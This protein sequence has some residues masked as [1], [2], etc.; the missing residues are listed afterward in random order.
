MMMMMMFC[1]GVA[2]A[3]VCVFTVVWRRAEGRDDGR[4]GGASGV[5][6]TTALLAAALCYIVSPAVSGVVVLCCVLMKICV[7]KRRG[8][9][10]TRGAV[11]ITGCD[12]G[13]GHTLALQLSHMGVTV[14]AGVLDMKGGGAQRLRARASEKLQVLQ[15]DVTD[16]VQVETARQYVCAQVGRTGLWGLVNNAGILPCP[17]DAEL[18]PLSDY[19]RCMDVNFLSAVHMCQVFLPMLRRSRG[20]IVNV[21]SLA[22]EVPMP[23]F[24]AYGASKA[25]LSAFSTM[26]RLETSQWNVNVSLIQPSGFRTNLF[27]DSDVICRYKDHL[28]ASASSEAREDYGDSYILSLPSCLSSM[29]QTSAEDLSPVVD[30]MCHALLSVHP[31]AVYS[32]GQ[33]G[34]LL[35]FLHR[36]CPT[37]IFD[38]IITTLITYKV[39]EPAGLRTT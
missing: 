31:R 19:R 9:L 5:L 36:H 28:L 18:L 3:A 33:M 16:S 4:G 8:D 32:P 30:A 29:S 39:G 38:L 15:L 23:L 17:A 12:S 1:C 34:W 21:S 6:W 26:M 7:R 37:A 20:R 10:R 14:F 22:A 24:A 35:P 27:G 2:A 25:A 13:F 11:L